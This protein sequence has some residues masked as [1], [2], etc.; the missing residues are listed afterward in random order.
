M[1]KAPIFA[2][3][4]LEFNVDGS[5]IEHKNKNISL[6]GVTGLSWDPLS[7]SRHF[8]LK[9]IVNVT[10]IGP[11]SITMVTDAFVMREQTAF[12]EYMSIKFVLNDKNRAT[13]ETFIAETGFFPTQAMRKYPRIPRVDKIQTFPLRVIGT[14]SEKSFD[15][16]PTPI[17]FEVEDLSLGGVLVSSENPFALSLLPGQKV[18][19]YIE[20]RG[21]F[22]MQI[23]IQGMICRTM[24][25]RNPRSGN[26]VRYF[27][28]RFTKVDED[29]KIAYLELLRDILERIKREPTAP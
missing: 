29:N 21:N 16:D 7:P 6:F 24:E 25:E 23:S 3:G 8:G 4:N 14:P 12:G 17:V 1:D 18:S 5:T 20:P 9:V 13:L 15:T 2:K 27:G 28:I 19:M 22:S 10:L 11:Q 26:M